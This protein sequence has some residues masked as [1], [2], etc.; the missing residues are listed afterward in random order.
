MLS[1]VE[2]LFKTS[3][4]HLNPYQCPTQFF[5]NSKSITLT[6]IM[7]G[8][9]KSSHKASSNLLPNRAQYLSAE[10]YSCKNKVHL[11]CQYSNFFSEI[12]FK[13]WWVECDTNS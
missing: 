13:Y 11:V 7:W 6:S 3:K 5:I 9:I 12:Y 10:A 2:S 1:L 4:F 8:K